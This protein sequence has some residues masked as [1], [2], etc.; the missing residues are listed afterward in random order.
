MIIKTDV[1][2]EGL[3]EELDFSYCLG[4]DRLM[5]PKK[6]IPLERMWHILGKYIPEFNEFF[7]EVNDGKN[8][9]DNT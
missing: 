1:D 3:I 2:I 6:C 9:T 7:K 5:Q 8:T 4:G